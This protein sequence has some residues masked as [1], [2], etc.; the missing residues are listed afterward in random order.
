MAPDEHREQPRYPEDFKTGT[1]V[2]VLNCTECNAAGR[3]GSMK[4]NDD[5]LEWVC[6]KC[7]AIKPSVKGI[8]ANSKAIVAEN[9]FKPDRERRAG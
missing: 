3:V 1:E 5:G 4:M 9:G 7:G 2:E 6:S 8:I